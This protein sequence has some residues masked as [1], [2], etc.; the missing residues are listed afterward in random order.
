MYLQQFDAIVKQKCKQ[1][2]PMKMHNTSSLFSRESAISF[3]NDDVKYEPQASGNLV[4]SQPG[5]SYVGYQSGF[6]SATI[7]LPQKAQENLQEVITQLT[8]ALKNVED[9][10]RTTEAA[11]YNLEVKMYIEK[12]KDVLSDDVDNPAHVRISNDENVRKLAKVA[13]A[14]FFSN[15]SA[16]QIMYNA[17]HRRMPNLPDYS[18]EVNYIATPG[19]ADRPPTKYTLQGAFKAVIFQAIVDSGEYDIVR[20]DQN[21]RVA[22]IDYEKSFTTLFTSRGQAAI[23]GEEKEELE[24]ARVLSVLEVQRHQEDIT[25]E[26]KDAIEELIKK[27]T[28][29]LTMEGDIDRN[30]GDDSTP[31]DYQTPS[32]QSTHIP[33]YIQRP[34]RP[35]LG[36]PFPTIAGMGRSAANMLSPR[37]RVEQSPSNPQHT[38]FPDTPVAEAEH[39][40][41][42]SAPSPEQPS[43]ST[44]YTGGLF[45]VLGHLDANRRRTTL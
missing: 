1:H 12:I 24:K 32:G 43:S 18:D 45:G 36:N 13:E 25:D 6:R 3:R 41:V 14:L 40:P 26:Q 38:R 23:S 33:P 19:R 15:T 42:L 29:G 30:D 37:A 39:L 9:D 28:G 11:R 7:P 2:K 5:A 8:S 31:R 10:L 16:T 35:T 44:S 27:I 21:G 34:N 4:G 22:D 17:L 20:F